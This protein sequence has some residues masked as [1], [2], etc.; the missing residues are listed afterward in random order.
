VAGMLHAA[1]LL[2]FVLVAAPLAAYIPLAA[3]AGVLITV[4]WN[5]VEKHAFATLLRAS[6]GDAAV[7]LAT[8]L[9][10]VFRD[11]TEGIVVGFALGSVLFIYRMSRT[12]AIETTIPFVVEDK[13]DDANGGRRPYDERRAADP[14]I[15]IYRI[16]GAFFFG[17][18]ASIGTVLD[19]IADTHRALII[20]FAAVPFLDS[21]AANTIG[22]LARK[23]RRRHVAVYLTGTT[24]ELRKVLFAHGVKPPLVHYAPKIDD[25]VAKARR[26]V[27]AAA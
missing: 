14:D 3:L 21:T 15:V 6:T 19:R 2:L 13:A 18:A 17:A 5:M 11:L 22:G 23:A 1:F 26:T 10:T 16:S 9:L 25:A 24:H 12:T 27:A 4:A 7:L 20:D 8:F